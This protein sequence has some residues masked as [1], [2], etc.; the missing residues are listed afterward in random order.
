ML[1][2][3]KWLSITILSIIIG[4]I[5]QAIGFYS[6]LSYFMLVPFYGDS[7]PLW[8]NTLTN[9]LQTMAMPITVLIGQIIFVVYKRRKS[10]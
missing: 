2:L 5:L 10:K 6:Y 1:M 8:R 3:I 7:G 9:N 4:M